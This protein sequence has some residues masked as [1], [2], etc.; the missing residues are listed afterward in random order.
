MSS[1]TG[2]QK[3]LIATFYSQAKIMKLSEWL[4]EIQR[5]WMMEAYQ[6][7]KHTS[8]S[9]LSSTIMQ[10]GWSTVAQQ[11][12]VF[13]KVI[14]SKVFQSFHLLVYHET[15]SWFNREIQRL[16]LSSN[17]KLKMQDST[18]VIASGTF[19]IFIISSKKSSC[20]WFSSSFFA[21]NLFNLSWL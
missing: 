1:S 2:L 9:S 10:C 20:L 17:S 3:E 5:R 15:P 19:N 8:M 18:G 16:Q 13:R 12:V 4:T 7:P 21:P 6:I 14:P 11:R